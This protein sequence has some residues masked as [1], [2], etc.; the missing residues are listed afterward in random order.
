MNESYQFIELYRNDTKPQV[1][2]S[3]SYSFSAHNNVDLSSVET[4][5]LYLKRS[6][7]QDEYDL[8]KEVS[9]IDREKGKAVIVWND[10]DLDLEEGIYNG[11]IKIQY[12]DG[13]VETV[14]QT[15]KF[16]IRE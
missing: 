11:T 4:I 3:F 10:D 16:R 2:L 7:Y 13:S 9:M 5:T 12:S 14:K 8:V 15:L 6:T 1:E